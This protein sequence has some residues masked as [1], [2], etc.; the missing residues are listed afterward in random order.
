MLHFGYVAQWESF[1]GN[2]ISRQ[3][4]VHEDLS[5]PKQLVFFHA[6]FTVSDCGPMWMLIKGYIY[7]LCGAPRR[8]IGGGPEGGA[9]A[10]LTAF[11]PTASWWAL[12]TL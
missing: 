2:V 1:R 8:R 12:V 4:F 7:E 9:L 6:R 10:N 3:I 11:T 5:L